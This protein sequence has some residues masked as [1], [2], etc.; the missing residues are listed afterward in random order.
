MN[1]LARR[2]M[3]TRSTTQGAVHPR[4]APG[5]CARAHTSTCSTSMST[6][7]RHSTCGCGWSR[8]RPRPR[9]TFDADVGEVNL[10][11]SARRRDPRPRRPDPRGRARRQRPRRRP[12]RGRAA[13]SRG[14]GRAVPRVARRQLLVVRDRL[15]GARSRDAVRAAR[16]AVSPSGSRP[17][18]QIHAGAAAAGRAR[19]PTTSTSSARSRHSRGLTCGWRCCY[20]ISPHAGARSSPAG[21]GCRYR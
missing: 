16:R 4:W 6:S 11:P 18:P 12:D 21:S 10:T 9:F 13:R 2:S 20:G 19:G 8:V 17:W 3:L 15:A 1:L 7:P 14:P 5:S